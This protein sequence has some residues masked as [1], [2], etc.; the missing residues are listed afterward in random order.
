[1]RGLGS[2]LCAY[3]YC[4]NFAGTLAVC[5]SGFGLWSLVRGFSVQ[6]L[7]GPCVKM[8]LYEGGCLT[9]LGR[10]FVRKDA[11]SHR[12]A[13]KFILVSSPGAIYIA[14]W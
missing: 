10:L 11:R 7:A 4:P 2:R 13:P 14:Y 6:L 8:G 9:L 3:S 5:G 12:Q 1:M